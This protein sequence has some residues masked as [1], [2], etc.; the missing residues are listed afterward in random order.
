MQLLEMRQLQKLREIEF[1]PNRF[2]AQNET[3]SR[4]KRRREK[5]IFRLP[6]LRL[7][8]CSYCYYIIYIIIEPKRIV[9]LLGRLAI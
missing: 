6:K 4:T 8:K 2:S 3:R 7:Y 5:F 9:K 1:M